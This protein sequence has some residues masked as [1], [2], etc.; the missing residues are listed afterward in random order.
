MFILSSYAM[1][2]FFCVITMFCWG[3]W[4]NAQKLAEKQWRFELFYWDFSL[5]V[6]LLSLLFALTLGNTGGPGR[7]FF[8]DLSQA[9]GSNILSAF[10]GGIIFNIA[11]TLLVVAIDIAGMAVAFPVG[12]GIALVLGIIINYIAA[13]AGNP[14]ILFSGVALVVVAI[15]LDAR[16]YGKLSSQQHQVPVKGIVFSVLCGILMGLFYRFVASAMVTNFSQP[17]MG[18]LGPYSAVV[19]FSAGVLASSFIIVPFI[20]KKP[21]KGPPVMM[22]DYFRGNLRNHLTG[23]LGGLI[24]CIGMSFSILA[25]ERAGFAISYGL[26]QGATMVAACWGVFFWKEFKGAP[27]GTNRLLTL[28]MIAYV[29]GLACIILARVYA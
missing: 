26:G 21:V 2:V 11:N 27:A 19:C 7:P 25:S 12:I 8:S 23:I 29:L 5:G 17:E 16:A 28:M 1:A 3:S 9:A 15:L 10:I 6:L 14:V 13:P 20:M 18:K 22:A 4:A 24:W